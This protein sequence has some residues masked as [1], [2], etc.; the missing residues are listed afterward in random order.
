[1]RKHTKWVLAV[2][3]AAFPF[4]VWAADKAGE[5]ALELKTAQDKTSYVLGREVGQGLRES[6]SKIDLSVFMRGI[7]DSLNKRPSLLTPEEEN[8]VKADFSTQMKEEQSKKWAAMVEQNQKA[9]EDFLTRNKPQKG[10]ITTP[11][12]LQYQIIKEGSGASIKESDQVK[13]H[14]RGTLIDGTEFDSSYARN[15]PA[16]FAVNGVIPGWTEGLQLMKIGGKY[17]IWIPSKLAYGTRGAGQT[18][19]PNTLLIFDVEPLE[20]AN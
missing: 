9:E 14:Y 15:Q 12:G 4:L 20:I 1:M 3:A 6:P 5:K 16:V 13:V 19:G 8:Q 10:V 11:S 2:L 17:R 18:I 7:Q